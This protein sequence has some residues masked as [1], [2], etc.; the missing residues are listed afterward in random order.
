[1]GLIY[2]RPDAFSPAECEAIIALGEAGDPHRAPVYGR[3]GE[4]AVD[5]NVR[6]VRTVAV[7]GHNPSIGELAGGL[8]DGRGDPEARRG[9]RS[10]FPAD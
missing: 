10:G 5:T 8:D 9:V 7:V 1:M 4:E 3:A 2:D 6:N